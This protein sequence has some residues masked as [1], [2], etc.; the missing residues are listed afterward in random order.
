MLLT[1]S[2]IKG[3][4][5]LTLSTSHLQITLSYE[6]NFHTGKSK[7]DDTEVTVV[8]RPYC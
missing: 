7:I 6:E 5:E 1:K 8:T 4:T 2:K 3:F